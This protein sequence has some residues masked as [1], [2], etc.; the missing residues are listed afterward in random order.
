MISFTCSGCQKKLQAKPEM[1][2]KRVKCPGCGLTTEV[3]AKSQSSPSTVR[4]RPSYSAGAKPT[5]PSDKSKVRTPGAGREQPTATLP[6]KH[7]K[8]GANTSDLTSNLVDHLSVP[9]R[10]SNDAG[11]AG[12]FVDLTSFLSLPQSKDELG[13]LGG[14]RILKVLGHGGMGVVFLAEDPQLRRKVAIKAMRPHLAQSDVG[15][16]RFLREARSAAALEHDNIVPIH[17][18]A[19]DRGVPYIVMPLLRGQSLED[20]LKQDEPI[21]LALM[22][23]VG[24]ELGSALVAAHGQGLLHRD[25]KPANIWLEST[26]ARELHPVSQPRV[27]LLDFGLARLTVVDEQDYLTQSGAVIG[28]PGYM[29][30][31]QVNGEKLD[32]RADLFSLGCVLYRM[33]AG[34]VAFPGDTIT[35]RLLSVT[36][37]DPEPPSKLNSTIPTELSTLIEQMLAK[38][39]EDRPTSAH[40]IVARLAALK[41]IVDEAAP[42]IATP[43]GARQQAGGKSPLTEAAS[44]IRPAERNLLKSKVVIGAAAATM[45]LLVAG[46][47]VVNRERGDDNMAQNK[48][49]EDGTAQLKPP[50]RRKPPDDPKETGPKIVLPGPLDK[51]DPINIPAAERF[52]WQP[53]DLVGVLGKHGQMH[54]GRVTALAINPKGDL[55]AAGNGRLIYLWDIKASELKRVLSGGKLGVGSLEFSR[56]GTEFLSGGNDQTV[57]LWDTNSGK[58]KSSFPGYQGLY[59]SDGRI[60]T[61]GGTV[62]FWDLESGKEIDNP[63]PLPGDIVV[64]S[65]GGELM[66]VRRKDN[67][68]HLLD[69]QTLTDKGT[70]KGHTQQVCSMAISPDGK[71]VASATHNYGG[72]LAEIKIW[73]AKS[74]EE[75]TT[76]PANSLA[77]WSITFSPD[78]KTLAAAQRYAITIWETSTWKKQKDLD[79]LYAQVFSLAYAAD[80]KTLVSGGEDHSVQVWDLATGKRRSLPE[81]P[82]WKIGGAM[83]FAADGNLL[84][85]PFM[86]RSEGKVEIWDLKSGKPRV[87][88][89][90]GSS[91]HSAA[92]SRDGRILA[93]GF[94]GSI[95]LKDLA[96]DQIK[97]RWELQNNAYNVSFT[98][99]SGSLVSFNADGTVRIWDVPRGAQT[100]YFKGVGVPA[101]DGKTIAVIEPEKVVAIRDV[102][103]QKVLQTIHLDDPGATLMYSA[104]GKHLTTTA[105]GLMRFWDPASGKEVRQLP[106]PGL[107]VCFS[108]DGAHMVL[109]DVL[110]FVLCDL[111]TGKELKRWFFP[112]DHRQ[113]AIF[114]PDGRHLL[115]GNENG[116]VYVLRLAPSK[117][118][119]A[120]KAPPGALDRLAT[121]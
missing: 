105:N 98:H 97:N 100:G 115:V 76:L 53:N 74:A 116:T 96:S 71:L 63:Q 30:P 117:A 20:R 48:D 6:D 73:D 72:E 109:G 58:E 62:K 38:K 110:D 46:V 35:A 9:S 95:Y 121:R 34:K 111:A 84:A 90:G 3:M 112:N 85:V 101:P 39:R 40:E 36:I 65:R 49:P 69:A 102:S 23:Q 93:G 4:P 108:P 16:E 78:G 81:R 45:L 75:I 83:A 82:W 37:H 66:A 79:G 89:E 94:F 54:W 2:G 114:S 19:E 86:G 21:P 33:A 118:P 15:R 32:G 61:A 18:V 31:E 42:N 88:I 10:D 13:R 22:L 55:V 91:A 64:Y 28:T 60:V 5:Q 51:L 29:P 44:K 7:D 103:T 14:F 47:F 25:I 119:E 41:H 104:N 120:K 12:P 52:P 27:K 70:L 77:V 99:D 57:K 1:L 50:P 26:Q 11:I 87:S 8:T 80:G 43:S 56:D 59:C 113:S 67:T 107:P 92:F 24:K 68:I 17:H 106:V